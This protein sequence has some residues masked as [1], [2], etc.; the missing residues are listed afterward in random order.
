MSS[1]E[2][3]NAAAPQKKNMEIGIAQ[4]LPRSS[5]GILETTVESKILRGDPA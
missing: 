5:R 2:R 4:M 1:L 3:I